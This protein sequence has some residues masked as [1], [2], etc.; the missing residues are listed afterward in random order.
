MSL[1]FA[2]SVP[3]ENSAVHRRRMRQRGGRRSL[4]M[5]ADQ[6]RA[7]E[8]MAVAAGVPVSRY[9]TE[10]LGLPPPPPPKKRT[11]KPSAKRE[12]AVALWRAGVRVADIARSV[13]L[14]A[15]YTRQLLRG[16]GFTLKDT[17]VHDEEIVR[18]RK[19]GLTHRVIGERVGTS[20]AVVAAAL[21]RAGMTEPR[22]NPLVFTETILELRSQG[23][24]QQ[25]IGDAVGFSRK[26]IARVLRLNGIN[27]YERSRSGDQGASHFP[28]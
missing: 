1:D 13:G 12:R 10:A 7:L 2:S 27:G 11:P 20:R 22:A 16:A 28:E 9:V 3:L 17:L 4:S 6:Y 24:T 14:S 8:E 23:L 15:G 21:K 19:E 26:T 25:Q 18:L 5:H